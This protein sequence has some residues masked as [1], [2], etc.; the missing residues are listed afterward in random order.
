[1]RHF[2]QLNK[3]GNT[4]KNETNDRVKKSPDGSFDAD[5]TGGARGH[6]GAVGG[7]LD[8]DLSFRCLRC[9]IECHE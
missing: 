8:A 3:D 7:R 1:V 9:D 5:L 2:N 6:I 4:M